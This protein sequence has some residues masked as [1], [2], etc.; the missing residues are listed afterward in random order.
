[1][2]IV[3]SKDIEEAIKK[4]AEIAKVVPESLREAAFNRALDALLGGASPRPNKGNK[5]TS[6]KDQEHGASGGL[7]E[8]LNRTAYPQITQA[9]PVL[10]RALYILRAARDD[11]A[12]DGLGAA[13]IASILT[14]KFR[15]RTSRQAVT[16]ALDAA[17][18]KVDRSKKGRNVLYRLMQ[19]GDDYLDT[20]NFNTARY[21]TP[22]K[23]KK[24]KTTIVKPP[25]ADIPK[26][27]KAPTKTAKTAP[28]KGR[29]GPGEILKKLAESG[30]FNEARSI[31]DIQ[32]YCENKLAHKYSLMELSTPLRRAVH[33]DLLTRD[34]NEEGNFEYSAK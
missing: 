9:L 1:M 20:G 21:S 3:M 16:Q 28:K 15:L 22:G 19:P 7:R 8:L 18:D 29:P 25:A 5:L 2:E 10:E 30:F 17:G 12:I 34:K 4:A 27:K 14:E 32:L 26:K 33:S 11:Y 6:K 24:K 13:E 31:T 23:I